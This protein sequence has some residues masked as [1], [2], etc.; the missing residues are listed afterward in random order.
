MLDLLPDD[1]LP[2]IAA[3]LRHQRDRYQENAAR[4]PPYVPVKL[5][6]VWSGV[7]VSDD[8]I[9]EVRREPWGRIGER[10]W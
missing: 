8:D 9:A 6:G 3:Y 5:E 7:A 1:L 4:T 10:D 2:E